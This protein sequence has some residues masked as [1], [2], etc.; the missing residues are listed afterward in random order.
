MTM[1]KSSPT[2]PLPHSW[3]LRSWETAAPHVWPHNEIA[4]RRVLRVH[5]T[6]LQAA[7]ALTRIGRNLV[8]LGNGYMKW[9]ASQ[10][11]NVTEYDVPMNRPEHAHKRFHG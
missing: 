7:G 9:L 2:I 1:I 11:A 3:D 10:A 6:E 5:R 4:A 8:V